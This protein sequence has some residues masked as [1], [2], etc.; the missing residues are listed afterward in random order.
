MEI[1]NR[2]NLLV[3]ED[4]AQAIDSFYESKVKVKGE[5]EQRK[6]PV[7]VRVLDFELPAPKCYGDDNLD[8]YVAS[9]EYN[10]IAMLME[11]NGGDYE[12]GVKQ[13]QAQLE[14]HVSHNQNFNWIRQGI[15]AESRRT[16]EAMRAAGMQTD[17]ILGGLGCR[18]ATE[19]E[20]KAAAEREEVAIVTTP[21]SQFAASVA[22]AE[23]APAAR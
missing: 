21:L 8:F 23:L 18:L 4:A 17:V 14:D 9:Y 11:Q 7:V 3:V 6:I 5:G 2:H 22:L 19:A 15:N 1:A 20:M 10:G 12:L 13:L 16:V